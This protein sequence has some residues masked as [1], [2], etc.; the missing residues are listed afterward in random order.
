P[1][2]CIRASATNPRP[3]TPITPYPTGRLGGTNK[4]ADKLAI[5]LSRPV[6]PHQHP[7]LTRSRAHEDYPL[8]QIFCGSFRACSFFYLF[9][10]LRPAVAGLHP[11]LSCSAPSALKNGA[12]AHTFTRG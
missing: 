10:G 1:G 6:P 3:V 8:L 4:C 2:G 11:T 7:D 9:R 12:W 5:Q